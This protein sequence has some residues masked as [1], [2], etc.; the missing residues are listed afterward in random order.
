MFYSGARAIKK[1]LQISRST[2]SDFSAYVLRIFFPPQSNFATL[3]M[4]KK[5]S[6]ARPEEKDGKT[7][8]G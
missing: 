3:E 2:K 5:L 7:K 6:W 8:T 4:M 1:A